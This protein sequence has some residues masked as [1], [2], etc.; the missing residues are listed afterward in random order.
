MRVDDLQLRA[1]RDRE[2]AETAKRIVRGEVHM[3]MFLDRV[4]ESEQTVAESPDC[5]P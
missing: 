4:K 5:I 2:E 1:S 3:K